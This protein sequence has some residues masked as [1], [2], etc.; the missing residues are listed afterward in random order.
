[1]KKGKKIKWGEEQK[2][3]KK[4]KKDKKKRQIGQTIPK[5]AENRNKQ[6]H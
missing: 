6:I 1:L 2:Q 3:T 5:A 4:W